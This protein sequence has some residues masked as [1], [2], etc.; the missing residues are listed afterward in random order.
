MGD[1]CSPTKVNGFLSRR[2]TVLT[3]CPQR[4]S[5]TSRGAHI[6]QHGDKSYH[7]QITKGNLQ[8]MMISR[9]L[10]PQ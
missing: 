5:P 1:G 8:V 10:A 4:W 3:Y 7:A 6:G 2:S 9:T